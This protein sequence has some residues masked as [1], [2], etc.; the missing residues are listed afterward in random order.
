MPDLDG[1]AMSRFR[2][3]EMPG[4]EVNVAA[5]AYDEAIAM[6][7]CRDSKVSRPPDGRSVSCSYPEF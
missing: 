4:I 2:Q 1:P 6:T 7:G 5:G 3:S